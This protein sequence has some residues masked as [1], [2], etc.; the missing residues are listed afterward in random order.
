VIGPAELTV[1]SERVWRAVQA[2]T[3]DL[4]TPVA[5][6]ML[7]SPT[8]KVVTWECE[9]LY[10]GNRGAGVFRLTGEA[11]C[12]GG[13]N[14]G[15]HPWSAVL[16]VIRPHPA[17]RTDDWALEAQLYQSGVLSELPAGL[18][19]PRCYAVEQHGVDEWWVWME[20]IQG[21]LGLTWTRDDFVRAARCLGRFNG[22]YLA[23][24]PLPDARWLRAD[25][26]RSYVKRYAPDVPRLWDGLAQ[27]HPL[28]CRMCPPEVA[29]GLR[30]LW[31]ATE[32]LLAAIDRLPRLFGHN[33]A[34]GRNL[35]LD[36]VD[37]AEALVAVDWDFGGQGR[38]G[39]EIVPLCAELTNPGQHSVSEAP[40][41][42]EAIY[43]AYLDGLR[44]AGW[45]GDEQL[46][47]LGYTA[48]FAVR[49]PVQSAAYAAVRAL[50]P[51]RR[52]ELERYWGWEIGEI[53]DQRCAELRSLLRIADEALRLLE[54]RR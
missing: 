7:G 30:R 38:P 53:M 51:S 44:D 45:R 18:R 27:E 14:V 33:D 48:S 31:K 54:T 4:L 42:R 52:I 15:P 9:R 32:S 3:A 40:A 5:Q 21:R 29:E 49:Y 2:L 36:A 1:V 23:G 41:L 26:L 39:Q 46:V 37:G 12:R 10:G 16:K 50:D 43:A 34:G 28:V 22:A 17:Y 11:I 19:A 8:A 35:F 6:H 25:A 24:Y 20:S 13:R 47:R